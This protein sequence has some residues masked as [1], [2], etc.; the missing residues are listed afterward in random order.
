MLR[1]SARRRFPNASVLPGFPLG[2]QGRATKAW[3]GRC[4]KFVPTILV[5][6]N[7]IEHPSHVCWYCAPPLPPG[8]NPKQQSKRT[9][10]RTG[11]PLASDGVY[12]SASKQICVDIGTGCVSIHIC[13][14]VCIYKCVCMDYVHTYI[15]I[16]AHVLIYTCIHVCID[17]HMQRCAYVRISLYTHAYAHTDVS[18]YLCM[19][20][21]T[22][23]QTHACMDICRCVYMYSCV[24]A[25]LCIY[26]HTSR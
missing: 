2:K 6:T 21:S 12:T 9:L 25:C 14:H 8:P 20:V 11:I 22:H 17:V 10:T 19:C 4:I 23:M 18:M 16:C 26:I 7:F 3:L 13:I 5:G 15:C 1:N 24:Y